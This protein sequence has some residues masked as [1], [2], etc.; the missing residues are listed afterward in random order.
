MV[1]M[2]DGSKEKLNNQSKGVG[3]HFFPKVQHIDQD[4]VMVSGTF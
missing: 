3:V 4:V 1:C 2:V